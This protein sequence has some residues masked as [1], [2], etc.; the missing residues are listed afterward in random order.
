M[1][2]PLI[3]PDDLAIL[4]KSIDAALRIAARRNAQLTVNE[5]AAQIASAFEAGERDPTKLAEA[6]FAPQ[7]GLAPA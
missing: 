6:V 7:S 4:Q 2:P 1:F 3:S 5:L